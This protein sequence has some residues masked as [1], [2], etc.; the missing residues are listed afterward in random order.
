[1]IK[2]LE[3]SNFKSIK[4]LRLDCKRINLF[5]GQPNAGKSNILESLGLLSYLYHSRWQ[6]ELRKFVRFERPGN[7]FYDESLEHRVE[8]TWDSNLMKLQFQNGRF[9]GTSGDALLGGDYTGLQIQSYGGDRFAQFKF[10]RFEVKDLFTKRETDFLLPPSGD[11]LASLLLA[12]KGLRSLSN[13]LIS[14]MG[15]RLGLRPQENKLEVIK[16]YE[17]IIVSYPYHLLSDTLQRLIFYLAA[18]LSNKGKESVLVFEEPESHAFPYYTK[19]L[20][21]IIA[22][23]ESDHQYFLTTHNPY[24]LLPILEKAPKEDVAVFITYFENYETKVKQLSEGKI[25]DALE[26]DVFFNLER[27]LEE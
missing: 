7:L 24:F 8:I 22:L 4:H 1:M 14:P 10:Y 21:E 5:I 23:D 6:N 9:D 26:M 15:L 17:D 11:N 25:Q 19:Y 18:I 3:I 12:N 16:Q 20:A 2:V 27:F 13:D